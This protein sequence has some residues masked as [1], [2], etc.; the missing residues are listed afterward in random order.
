MCRSRRN[1]TS[2]ERWMLAGCLMTALTAPGWHA[3]AASS[4]PIVVFGTSLSDPGNAFA[5]N[6][7]TNTHAGLLG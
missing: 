7:G 4:D 2:L 6:R 3:A 1:L 5:L